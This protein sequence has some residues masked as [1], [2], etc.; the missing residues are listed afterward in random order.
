MNRSNVR[1][2]DAHRWDSVA[3][4]ARWL[5]THADEYEVAT[6]I[7]RNRR[8]RPGDPPGELTT[9][10]CPPHPIVEVVGSLEMAKRIYVDCALEEE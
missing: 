7:L 5:L 1:K 10:T 3:D 2:L 9:H 4:L 6:L 8:R